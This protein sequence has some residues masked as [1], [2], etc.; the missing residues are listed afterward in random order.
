MSQFTTKPFHFGYFNAIRAFLLQTCSLI[1]C[2]SQTMI[3]DLPH[4]HILICSGLMRL[5]AGPAVSV[6][7]AFHIAAGVLCQSVIRCKQE[8]CYVAV[9][10]DAE[11]HSSPHEAILSPYICCLQQAWS[12]CVPGDNKGLGVSCIA[13]QL[14]IRSWSSSIR[15]SSMFFR[16]TGRT[17]KGWSCVARMRLLP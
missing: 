17:S 4:T 12:H 3:A 8:H 16:S 2:P 10:Q 13:L 15:T 1:E 14:T 11:L 9:T 7:Q 5:L 6:Q